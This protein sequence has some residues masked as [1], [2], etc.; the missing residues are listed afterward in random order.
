M[1]QLGNGLRV[2]LLTREELLGPVRVL[3]LLTVLMSLLLL[4]IKHS[5]IELVLLQFGRWALKL[6]LCLL[7]L[8]VDTNFFRAVRASIGFGWNLS[9]TIGMKKVEG[10]LYE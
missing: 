6:N 4:L 7:L 10:I 8:L 2:L 1:R 5:L 9:D 3:L